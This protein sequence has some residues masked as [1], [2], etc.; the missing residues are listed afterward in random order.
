LKIMVCGK[1]G[2]G[3][4][5]ISVLAARVLPK[6]HKVYLLDSDESN[7]LL[8]KLLGVKPPRSIVEYLGGK[9]TFSQ[10]EK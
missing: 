3:K 4:S 10:K 7:V 6:K 1:G 5:S 2:S 9:K 8:P